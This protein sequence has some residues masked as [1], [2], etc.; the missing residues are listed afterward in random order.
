MENT[1]NL[2][3]YLQRIGFSG[4]PKADLPTL[5]AIQCLHTQAIPFENLSPFTSTPV[6]IDL[7]AIEQKMVRGGRGGYCFEQNH[8]LKSVLEQIGFQVKGLAARVVWNRPPDATS[9]FSHM[10]LLVEIDGV[11]YIADVGFGSMSLTTPL[12][13]KADIVQ[14]TPH[15]DF[16][17]VQD[18]IYYR[19]EGYVKGEWKACY[20]FH[21]EE[22]FLPDY[23]M[24]NWY[25]SCNPQSHFTYTVIAARAFDGGRHTLLNRNFNTHYTDQRPS[26]QRIFE[27]PIEMRAV[28]QH[29][30]GLNLSGLPNLD[31]RLIASWPAWTV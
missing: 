29:V 27:D 25:T 5:Q 15:E 30:F 16:R 20:K 24:M 1:I 19:V 8:L 2:T 22:Q 26:D 12:L 31:E 17:L 9:P 7:N 23:Q 4:T 14:K 18:G 21:M 11:G 10:L 6:V 3:T 13:L 28:L